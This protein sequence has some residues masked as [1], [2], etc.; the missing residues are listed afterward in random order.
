MIE[1]SGWN[2]SRQM[3][4]GSFSIF[5]KVFHHAGLLFNDD[6]AEVLTIVNG[7]VPLG[8]NYAKM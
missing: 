7:A 5:G 8:M 3:D 2:A 1:L 4:C 6:K